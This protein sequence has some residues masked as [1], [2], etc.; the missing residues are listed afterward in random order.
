MYI[1]SSP[2][3]I[4]VRCSR[5]PHRRSK[6]PKWSASRWRSQGTILIGGTWW[7]YPC[8]WL[9]CRSPQRIQ[10]SRIETRTR[11][12]SGNANCRSTK[13]NRCPSYCLRRTRTLRSTPWRTWRLLRWSTPWKIPLDD[14]SQRW[15]SNKLSYCKISFIRLVSTVCTSLHLKKYFFN[16]YLT[17]WKKILQ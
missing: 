16:Y 13:S 14:I 4:Q 5:C 17:R 7:H 2:I 8:R 1:G 15:V 12:P 3:R 10:R 11:C 6:I 9:H